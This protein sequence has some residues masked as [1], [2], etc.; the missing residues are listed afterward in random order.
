MLSIMLD[1]IH[2]LLFL[3]LCQHNPP[4]PTLYLAKLLHMHNYLINNYL[5]EFFE[6]IP[7]LDPI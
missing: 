3:K 7:L 1:A 2:C 6:L 5:H 4:K